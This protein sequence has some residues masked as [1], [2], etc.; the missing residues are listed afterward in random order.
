MTLTLTPSQPTMDEWR[1][2]SYFDDV[3]VIGP[4]GPVLPMSSL[5]FISSSALHLLVSSARSSSSPLLLRH[6]L[7]LSL[8]GS[9]SGF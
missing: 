5:L 3:D 7:V 6:A 4:S 1:R 2:I 8:V 9:Q